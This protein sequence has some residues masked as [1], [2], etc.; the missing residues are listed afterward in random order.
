MTDN[1]GTNL[2]TVHFVLIEIPANTLFLLAFTSV[3][4]L[5]YTTA[6]AE[7]HVLVR[8]AYYTSH[9]F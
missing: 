7:T 3:A 1:N 8:F 2:H 9:Y 4:I 6:H 5:D